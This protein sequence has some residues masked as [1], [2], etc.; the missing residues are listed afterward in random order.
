ME[1]FTDRQRRAERL[2]AECFEG[3]RRALEIDRAIACISQCPYLETPPNSVVELF[4]LIE[5]EKYLRARLY[6]QMVEFI[7]EWKRPRSKRSTIAVGGAH[8]VPSWQDILRQ[9]PGWLEI[10]GCVHA[11]LSQCHVHVDDPGAAERPAKAMSTPDN[12]IPF[13]GPHGGSPNFRRVELVSMGFRWDWTYWRR[14]R[15]ILAVGDIDHTDEV[16]W[17][18]RRRRWARRCPHR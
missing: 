17:A 3:L 8:E 14:G 18:R 6:H 9:P 1:H 5:E 15:V 12:V 10:L 13:P 11:L 2:Y 7:L 4:P 16:T